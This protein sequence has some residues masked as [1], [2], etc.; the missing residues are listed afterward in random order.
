MKQKS[1]VILVNLG[2]PTDPSPRSVSKFLKKFLSDPRVV[3]APKWIWWFVL[4]LLVIPLRVK[5]VSRAYQEIWMEQGS[6]LRVIAEKQREALQKKLD[7]KNFPIEVF[8]GETYGDVSLKQIIFNLTKKDFKKI[9]LL[10]MYPQ[11]SC[12]TTGAIYDQVA[13]CLLHSR[14]VPDIKVVKSFH[15]DPGYISSLA[16]SVNTF[17]RENGKGKKLLISFHGVPQSYVDKGDPYQRQCLETASLLA[18]QLGLANEEWQV[19]FQSRFGP[20]QWLQPYTD[21]ILKKLAEQKI[22]DVDIVSPAF[23]ADCLE[24]L[25]E[26]A[27]Q[28]KKIFLDAGG[29]KYG[30]IPCLNDKNEFIDALQ[31]IVMRELVDTCNKKQV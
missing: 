11:Y 13:D 16:N 2:T 22:A 23:V 28:N 3:E 21:E 17:W 7:E 12:S 6:P 31:S 29:E 27:I 1:A 4:R 5:R 24:T 26:L 18:K 14:D 9:L 15:D 10:P 25:E 30:F 20:K 8:N 19:T